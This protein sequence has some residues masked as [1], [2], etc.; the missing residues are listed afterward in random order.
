MS[1]Y[2]ASVCGGEEEVKL[3]N[4]VHTIESIIKPRMPDKKMKCND[5]YQKLWQAKADWLQW[6][7]MPCTAL[8]KYRFLKCLIKVKY[9]CDTLS[10][11]Y[12]KYGICSGTGTLYNIPEFIFSAS[13]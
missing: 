7:T 12:L 13:E 5:F 1:P 8:V 3:Q 9:T 10:L 6:D 4:R 11:S 2:F